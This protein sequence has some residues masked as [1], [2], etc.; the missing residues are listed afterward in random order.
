M[1]ADT[2]PAP[3]L[4]GGPW[5]TDKELDTEFIK[6]LMN[7]CLKIVRDR[8]RCPTY[9]ACDGLTDTYQSTPETRNHQGAQ[10]RR[11]YP[12]SY[13]SYPTSQQI[14]VRTNHV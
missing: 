13:S 11:L 4:T 6:L 10:T 3:E 7:V 12:L 14:W 2:D 1:L 8:V 9:M 5:Y